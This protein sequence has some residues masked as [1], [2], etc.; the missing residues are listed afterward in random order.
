M[1]RLVLQGTRDPFGSPAEITAAVK[2]DPGVTVVE[3]P[4]AD[5]GLRV[6]R[7][8]PFDGTALRELLVAETARFL[9]SRSGTRAADNGTGE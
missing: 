5:H 3:L 9:L 2:H 1:P 7:R 4:G 8:A 6:N